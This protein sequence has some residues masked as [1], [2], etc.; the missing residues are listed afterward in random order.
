MSVKKLFWIDPY[1]RELPTTVT[2]VTGDV[3]TLAETIFYP[4]TGGQRPDEGTIGNVP[5]L[6]AEWDG[7]EIRYTL[8]PGHGLA[9]GDA[10]TVAIDWEKRYRTMRLHFADE[11]LIE[12]ILR[13]YENPDVTDAIVTSD[14][15]TA[16]FRWE[17]DISAIFPAMQ[18]KVC[19]M[20]KR[21]LEIISAFED[22]ENE[23]RYWEIEGF[24]RVPCN[25]THI[26]RTGEVGELHLTRVSVEPGIERIEL[27]LA[28]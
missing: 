26:R 27:R 11:L 18:E 4:F 6:S 2:G 24:K 12:W 13:T 17:G 19:D 7:M 8:P 14:M 23:R 10:V 5:V 20:V 1:K 9:A 3:V 15:A 25:G 22:E 21:D 16:E 28:N